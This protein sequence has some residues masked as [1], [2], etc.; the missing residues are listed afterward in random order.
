MTTP[1]T[2]MQA[3]TANTH[4][5]HRWMPEDDVLSCDHCGVRTYHR[6]ARVLCPATVDE[7]SERALRLPLL[8]EFEATLYVRW[9]QQGHTPVYISADDHGSVHGCTRCSA[10]VVFAWHRKSWS[11]SSRILDTTCDKKGTS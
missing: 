6:D 3:L 9:I 7:H 5:T 1:E 11:L 4:P 8:H 10:M 2:I